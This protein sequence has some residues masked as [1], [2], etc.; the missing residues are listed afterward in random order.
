M[1][2]LVWL[3]WFGLVWLV[4][5]VFECLASEVVGLGGFWNGL[6]GFFGD[7]VVVVVGIPSF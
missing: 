7:I 3:E 4:G 1:V 2:W 5:V 6:I